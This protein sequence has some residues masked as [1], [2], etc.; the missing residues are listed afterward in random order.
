MA[1][2]HVVGVPDLESAKDGTTAQDA[3]SPVLLEYY[4]M[5]AFSLFLLTIGIWAFLFPF[6]ESTI[7][8]HMLGTCGLVIALFVMLNADLLVTYL[9]L[10]REMQRFKQNNMR[11]RA[12]LVEQKAKI[13][14]LK[15]SE[16]ALKRLDRMCHGHMNELAG[17][18]DEMTH[19]ARD[20]TRRMIDGLMTVM[21]PKAEEV[22]AGADLNAVSRMFY[23][24]YGRAIS[25]LE[26]RFAE[27]HRGLDASQRWHGTQSLSL[28]RWKFIMTG[29]LF[30][31]IKGIKEFVQSKAEAESDERVSGWHGSDSDALDMTNWSSQ[32]DQRLTTSAT[33]TKEKSAVAPLSDAALIG[34]ASVR[35]DA[36]QEEDDDWADAEAFVAAG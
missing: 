28:T 16:K 14:Q 20:T 9:R 12:S 26:N 2:P 32:Y 24:I 34:S 8:G 36:Q 1:S 30:E 13:V 11:Y 6:S 35:Q 17:E 4:I 31:D 15:S 19:T 3:E 25:D 22:R 33:R 21:H 23:N 7:V 29:L 18:M 27:M 5:Y 10:L